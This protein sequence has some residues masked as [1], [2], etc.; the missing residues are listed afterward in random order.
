MAKFD[1][2]LVLILLSLSF[3]SFGETMDDLVER[4]DIYYKKFSDVPFTGNV[5]GKKQGSFEDGLEEGLWSSYW[6]NGQL[7][8]QGNYKGRLMEGPW[9][10]YWRNDQM[11]DK[12]N[13]K[14][15]KRQG[16]DCD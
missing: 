7:T 15:G 6:N 14:D 8:S 3:P 10:A 9:I 2:P 4:E 1:F 16:L 13:R 5:E 12:G 11:R